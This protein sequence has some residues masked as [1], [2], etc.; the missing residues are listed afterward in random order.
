MLGIYNRSYAIMLMPLQNITHVIG[1]IMF[2]ALS[3]IQKDLARVKRAYLRT[4]GVIALI[5][6]PLMAGLHVVSEQLVP[7]IFGTQ[8][9]GLVSILK[10]LSLLGLYQSIGSSVGWIYQ[11]QGRTDL[12]FRWGAIAALLLLLAAATGVWL[13]TLEAV[14]W[15]Y[16]IMNG[17]IL[18]WPTFAIPGK[19]IEMKV[20]EVFRAVSGVAACTLTMAIV[21]ELPKSLI[22]P[23]FSL[24]PAL[25]L[26]IAV[27]AAVYLLLIHFFRIKPYCE[28]RSIRKPTP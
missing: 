14:V 23:R 7:A 5:S 8:W 2:P 19:L 16:A 1:N 17:G 22:M 9:L 3:T 28:L 20:R 13:G 11:S 10:I 25:V 15:C 4:L 24:W 26:E 12:M 21:V 27:G 18:L 6:F